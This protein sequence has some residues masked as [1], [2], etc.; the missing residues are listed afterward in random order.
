MF[1]PGQGGGN[2]LVTAVSKFPGIKDVDRLLMEL[3]PQHKIHKEGDSG[4]KRK[5]SLGT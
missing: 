5:G 1:R 3:V 2:G 4:K